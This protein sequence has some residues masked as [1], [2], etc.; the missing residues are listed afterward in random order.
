[1]NKLRVEQLQQLLKRKVSLI[2]EAPHS[3]KLKENDVAFSKN[4]N[5]R[6]NEVNTIYVQNLI[7]EIY[8]STP[9]SHDDIVEIIDEVKVSKRALM[10]LGS[11]VTSKATEFDCLKI[12]MA[13]F[14]RRDKRIRSNFQHATEQRK[15][16]SPSIFLP[17]VKHAQLIQYLNR[18]K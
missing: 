12:F 7:L 1:L 2:G 5:R 16:F 15:P 8:N 17:P 6:L 14:R 13:I 10:Q 3:T 18:I 4:F 9:D 11:V